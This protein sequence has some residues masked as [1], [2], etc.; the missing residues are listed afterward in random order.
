[1]AFER[2]SLR[3]VSL[4][5]QILF[6]AFVLLG[7]VYILYSWYVQPIQSDLTRLASRIQSL[8]KEVQKGQ[9]VRAKLPEFKAQVQQQRKRL[10][11]FRETLPDKKRTAQLM[12]KIQDLATSS[13]L[14]IKSFTPQKTVPKTFYSN[15][16]IEIAL[17]GN[18]HNLGLFFEKVHYTSRLVNIENLSI[19]ALKDAAGR[20]R[21][22]GITC[23]A[24]TFVFLENA[25]TS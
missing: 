19:R 4:K 6:F 16:P 25:K 24:T 7:S 2:F 14:N 20:E 8:R 15:W 18:F 13:N 12:R 22:I 23:T 3:N 1:M 17:E 5:K 21:T 11:K 9:L 10:R